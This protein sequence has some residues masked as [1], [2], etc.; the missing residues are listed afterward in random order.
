MAETPRQRH[1][2]VKYGI[3]ESDYEHLLFMGGGKCYICRRPPKEGKN[4][5]IDHDHASGEIRGLLDYWCNRS[6][7]YHW[8]AER[9]KAAYEYMKGG[10]N[11]MYD[12]TGLFVPPRKKKRRKKR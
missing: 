11:L 2:R 4:L 7:S 8:T 10:R 9:L 5:Q 6:L 3:T 12:Y 1:L